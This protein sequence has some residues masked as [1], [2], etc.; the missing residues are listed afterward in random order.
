MSAEGSASGSEYA[1]SESE[2][3]RPSQSPAPSPSP[4]GKGKAKATEN[5]TDDSEDPP[6]LAWYISD[7]RRHMRLSE[8]A[9]AGRVALKRD[10]PRYINTYA[11]STVPPSNA[12]WTADEKAVLFASL[13]RHSRYR[14]DLIAADVR[15]K[16]E[17]L[18]AEY[19]AVLAWEAAHVSDRKGE[20]GESASW[21]AHLLTSGAVEADAEFAE[22]ENRLAEVVEARALAA[23]PKERKTKRGDKVE[24]V[25]YWGQ[26]LGVDKLKTLA[27]LL[28]AAEVRHTD[29]LKGIADGDED[30]DENDDP[31]AKDHREIEALQ[32]MPKQDRT[33]TQRRLLRTLLNRTAS[34]ER[35]R[36]KIL[37]NLGFTIAQ[38]D[39]AGGPDAMYASH[40]AGDKA[41]KKSGARR[42]SL[43][44]VPED[45]DIQQLAELGADAVMTERG[46]E[47]F[48]YARMSDLMNAS[49]R[50]YEG[51][52][53]A[54][55]DPVVK[56]ETSP[57]PPPA[58]DNPT[59]P[60]STASFA[61]IRDVY[62]ELLAYLKP[63]VYT[64][65]IIAEQHAVQTGDPSI[66]VQ[67]V[68]AALGLR[69][70]LDPLR[71]ASQLEREE[72][73]LSRSRS[74]S[75]SRG[76]SSEPPGNGDLSTSPRHDKRQIR[77]PASASASIPA[78]CRAL[79]WSAATAAPLLEYNVNAL[80]DT[81]S[82]ELEGDDPFINGGESDIEDQELDTA[83][84]SADECLDAVMAAQ[85]AAAIR[86]DDETPV[87]EGMWA[88]AAAGG[89]PPKRQ[90]RTVGPELIAALEAAQEGELQLPFCPVVQWW[91]SESLGSVELT[92]L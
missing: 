23:V 87:E 72:R 46:W 81:S 3:E 7:L 86:D 74:V 68:I 4:E 79:S 47:V 91:N 92:H 71:E 88:R 83:L 45:S 30:D 90:L 78:T 11:F 57:S 51:L 27:S 13:A 76:V 59:L 70:E 49:G 62:T 58:T 28:Q 17:S 56:R 5:A 19:L 69:G 54:F 66:T 12:V 53:T 40:L 35:S 43:A 29:D 73:G 82:D 75:V 63:L 6:G 36:T 48:N 60:T 44:E 21:R 8:H 85:L 67:H 42:K 34:R 64:S 77:R 32:S 1:A 61:V 16:S 15:T 37:V 14:P 26:D 25:E 9:L 84:A 31:L 22:Q 24:R 39:E 20:G 38:I 80:E 41:K 89:R 18:V 55:A 50:V 10:E 65:A 33:P 52:A 2:E